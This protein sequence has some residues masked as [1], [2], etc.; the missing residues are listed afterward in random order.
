MSVERY[1][2]HILHTNYTRDFSNIASMFLRGHNPPLCHEETYKLKSNGININATMRT[3]HKLM[4]IN[5][6]TSQ[7]SMNNMMKHYTTNHDILILYNV[8]KEH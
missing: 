6:F 2:K 7:N 4:I 1:S 3:T 8:S 5:N